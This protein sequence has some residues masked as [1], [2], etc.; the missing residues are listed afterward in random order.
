MI[1]PPPATDVAPSLARCVAELF[2]F[3]Q[4]HLP[5]PPERKI[6]FVPLREPAGAAAAGVDSSRVDAPPPLDA[7]ALVGSSAAA[8]GGAGSP[9]SGGLTVP[10]RV[11]RGPRALS[12]MWVA[13]TVDPAADEPSHSSSRANAHI[14]GAIAAAQ[15]FD[16][17]AATTAVPA[18][19][20]RLLAVI[21]GSG[22]SIIAFNKWT[23]ETVSK[24]LSE[25]RDEEA[26]RTRLAHQLERE[27]REHARRTRSVRQLSLGNVPLGARFARRPLDAEPSGEGG[28]TTVAESAP[29]SAARL[30]PRAQQATVNFDL[31]AFTQPALRDV[32]ASGAGKDHA[33]AAAPPSLVEL[34]AAPLDRKQVGGRAATD[35]KLIGCTPSSRSHATTAWTGLAG[36]S[37]DG[38]I[39]ERQSIG[40]EG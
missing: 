5:D 9:L 34:D 12:Q 14:T 18:D 2:V 37:A 3:Y 1:P 33:G 7:A 24:K 20:A 29:G 15:H 40:Q 30:R 10:Q 27:V 39:S 16:V 6:H 32:P 8:T 31:D 17:L 4:T 13:G 26:T 38:G 28:C 21:E 23:R 22:D 19:K 11:G 35:P 36:V 25:V